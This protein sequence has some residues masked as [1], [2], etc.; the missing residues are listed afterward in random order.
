[1]LNDTLFYQKTRIYYCDCFGRY[2]PIFKGKVNN[3]RGDVDEV[4]S[5]L[6][7]DIDIYFCK[8]DTLII[9]TKDE[10]YEVGLDKRYANSSQ[11][12]EKNRPYKKYSEIMGEIN[13]DELL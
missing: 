8:N 4:W 11:W 3:A 6:K 5:H 10:Y 12:N 7:D 13:N 1:M 2:I 9:F